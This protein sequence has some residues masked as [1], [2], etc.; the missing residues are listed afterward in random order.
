MSTEHK[1]RAVLT[2]IVAGASGLATSACD[3]VVESRITLD[4]PDNGP[5]VFEPTLTELTPTIKLLVQTPRLEKWIKDN[6]SRDARVTVTSY[7][8][9]I[10]G[11]VVAPNGLLTKTLPSLRANRGPLWTHFVNPDQEHWWEREWDP[12]FDTI[13]TLREFWARRRTVTQTWAVLTH[14]RRPTPEGGESVDFPLFA[15]IEVRNHSPEQDGQHME[16][17]P[18]PPSTA[19]FIWRREAIYHRVDQIYTFTRPNVIQRNWDRGINGI[20]RRIP[21][22]TSITP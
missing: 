7:P 10:K 6:L 20:R 5:F 1:R 18:L 4:I 17:P 3:H 11:K 8:E 22:V 2:R 9:V 13:V 21:L 14:L 15:A 12:E 16:L 19:E